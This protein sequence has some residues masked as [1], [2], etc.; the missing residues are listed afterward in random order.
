MI[1]RDFDGITKADIEAL[2]ANAVAEGRA[3]E[4][5]QQLPGNGDK[6]KKEFLADVSSFAN[7]GGGD[8]IFG[9]VEKRDGDNKPTDLPEKAEGLAGI[10]AGAEM[11]RLDA[12]IQSGIEPRIPGCRIRSID[13]FASGPVLVIRIPKSWA[14][15]HMVTFKNLSRFFTRTSAGKQQL[16]VGEIRLRSPPPAICGPKSPP[17]A[18][19]ASAKL[20]PTRGRLFFFRFAKGHSTVLL[21]H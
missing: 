4:Y 11:N 13:G 8:I 6:D 14:A 21:S 10:N 18:T 20:S 15:P 5:K 17:F 3:I 9:V 2:V 19:N 1:P 7:A 16:D 12:I